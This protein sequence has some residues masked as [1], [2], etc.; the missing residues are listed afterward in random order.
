METFTFTFKP[1]RHSTETKELQFKA[2]GFFGAA[3]KFFRHMSLHHPDFLLIQVRD[4]YGHE[5]YDTTE[6]HEPVRSGGSV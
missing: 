1:T 4:Q 5:F 2:L 3:A 6:K